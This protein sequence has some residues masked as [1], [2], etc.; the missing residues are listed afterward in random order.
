MNTSEPIPNPD[1]RA[2]DAVRTGDMERYRELVERH[3]RQVYAV[4]WAH[5]G[6]A[7]LAEDAVQESFIKAFRYL[8]W[9][10]DP[11]RFAAW[12]LRITRGV[13]INLGIRRRRELRRRERWSLDATTG[14]PSRGGRHRR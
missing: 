5:L 3:E 1:I 13:A 12:I 8:G 2:I 9:L 4:A 10:R 6:D 14:S 11:S 7:A